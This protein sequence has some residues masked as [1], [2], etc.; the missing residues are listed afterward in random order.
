MYS[1]TD[2]V[3]SETKLPAGLY[4]SENHENCIEISN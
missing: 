4:S 3:V 1:A 2:L